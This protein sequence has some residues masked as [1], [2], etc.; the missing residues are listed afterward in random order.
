MWLLFSQ[1]SV[2]KYYNQADNYIY[3]ALKTYWLRTLNSQRLK[4]YRNMIGKIV[5]Y[6]IFFEI[7]VAIKIKN[8]FALL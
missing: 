3:V 8:I 5:N 6:V 4:S 2:D 1:L 7:L